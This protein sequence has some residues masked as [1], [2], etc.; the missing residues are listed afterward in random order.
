MKIDFDVIKLEVSVIE[1]R[2][3]Y[4]CLLHSLEQTIDSHWV[5]HPNSYEDREG[6]RFHL[7]ETL[8][9]ATG[10]DWSHEKQQLRK[11]LDAAVAKRTTKPVA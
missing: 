5:M 10:H 6:E 7:L 3:I 8:A 11:R 4:Y 2:T 1:A 9:R